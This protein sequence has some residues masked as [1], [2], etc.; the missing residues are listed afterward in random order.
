MIIEEL[1]IYMYCFN[2]EAC[3]CGYS[4]YMDSF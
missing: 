3:A 2:D 1:F 4:M